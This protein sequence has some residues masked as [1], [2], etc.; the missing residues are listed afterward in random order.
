MYT[1]EIDVAYTCE[2]SY[3]LELLEK[4]NNP[5]IINYKSLGPAG[6]NPSLTLSFN[7]RETIVNFL[8]HIYNTSETTFID[9]QIINL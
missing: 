1:C 9:E 5:N 7:D 3:F 6:G 4:Y 2:I 8:K